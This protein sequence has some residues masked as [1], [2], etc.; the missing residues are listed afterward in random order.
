MTENNSSEELE[1]IREGL[2]EKSKDY[3]KE[4]ELE[5]ELKKKDEIPTF[6]EIKEEAPDNCPQ[7]KKFFDFAEELSE[8]LNRTVGQQVEQISEV[9][10]KAVEQQL[11]ELKNFSELQSVLTENLRNKIAHFEIPQEELEPLINFNEAFAS[12]LAKGSPHYFSFD[13]LG[14]D[15]ETLPELQKTEHIQLVD[16]LSKCKLG[17]I[18]WKRYEEI[19]GDILEYLLCPPLGDPIP[20]KRTVE[21]FEIRDWTLQIPYN[22][23]GFWRHI[24]QKYESNGLVVECKNLTDQI[25]KEH[26]IRCAEYLDSKRLGNFGI[27]LSRKPA[28]ESAK[29]QQKKAWFEQDKMILS[30]TDEDLRNMIKLKSNN[31]EIERYL[32]K[33]IFDFL[34]SLER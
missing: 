33:K 13:K 21:G 28:S 15:D 25:N 29:K 34:S 24:R 17:K 4:C 8:I 23:G 6:G 16:R 9:L 18:Q 20:Q 7:I 2:E 27:I 31:K 3:C 1:K 19:C 12:N 11:K 26:V 10:N 5:C 32:D 22:S 14:F 30:L